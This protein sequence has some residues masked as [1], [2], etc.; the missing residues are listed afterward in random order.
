MFILYSLVIGLAVG[1]LV[2][3]RVGG[4]ADL[5]IRW[6]LAMAVGLLVQILLFSTPLMDQVGAWGPV[7]YVASTSLVL[8]AIVV[9]RRIAGMPVVAAGA[10]SNLTAIVANR[11]YMPADLGAMAT[12]GRTS[13]DTYS[14]SA[15]LVDPALKPLTDVFALPAWVPFTNVFSV[16]DVIIAVGVAIVIVAAMRTPA[17]T[18]RPARDAEPA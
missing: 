4:L 17:P 13:I 9:N 1:F 14:N 7:I 12:L 16:G 5:R 8:V 2:G 6:Q 10:L 11:G 3:G 18:V 15:M